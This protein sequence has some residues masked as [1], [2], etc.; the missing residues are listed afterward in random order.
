MQHGL[1]VTKVCSNRQPHGLGIWD[2][3]FGGKKQKQPLSPHVIV[4]GH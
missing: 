4:I 3:F 1:V 2:D